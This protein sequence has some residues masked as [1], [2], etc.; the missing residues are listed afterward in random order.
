MDEDQYNITFITPEDGAVSMEVSGDAAF[1]ESLKAS[2]I[3]ISVDITGL[4]A[5]EHQVTM[6]VEVPEEVSWELPDDSKIV[7]IALAEKNSEG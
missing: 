2:D 6:N 1:L 4:K 7:T 3:T 5:G